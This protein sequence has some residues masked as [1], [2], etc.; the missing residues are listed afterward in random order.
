MNSRGHIQSRSKP[1]KRSAG[2][3]MIEAMVAIIV[4]SVG[5]LGIAGLQVVGLRNSGSANLR[6]QAA[7]FAANMIAEA[8]G[9]RADVLA[10]SPKVIGSTMASFSCTGSP[11]AD[12]SLEAW[13]ARI[14]C[15]LPDG[16]GAVTFDAF[17]RRLTVR[18]QWDDSRGANAAASGT[19][20]T[21]QTFLLETMI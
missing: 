5:L 19:T 12:S 6:G 4:L 2:F 16:Q 17:T 9:R 3:S 1:R 11:S 10:L 14:A 7:W 20:S 15:A 8:R 13:R 21:T 18:V